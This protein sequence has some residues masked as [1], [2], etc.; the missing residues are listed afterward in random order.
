MAKKTTPK[1][2]VSKNNRTASKKPVAKKAVK[3][4]KP[5]PASKKASKPATKK[6]AVKS[7]SKSK[8]S[9]P[10]AKK[11]PA[12]KPVKKVIPA[13]PV[14]HAPAK[15]SKPAK[16]AAKPAPKISAKIISST[17]K[18]KSPVKESSK[19]SEKVSSRTAPANM[20]P[21]PVAKDKKKSG[22]A[23]TAVAIGPVKVQVPVI[24][25]K[26]KVIVDY[27]NVPDEVLKSLSEKY[28]HGYNKAII[29][30]TNAKKEV[31]SAVPIDVSDTSYL[32]KVS[33]QLQKM[34]D[35]YDEEEM[36][37]DTV[38]AIAEKEIPAGTTSDFEEFDRSDDDETPKRS[39]T[40][41]HVRSADDLE[42]GFSDDDEEEDDDDDD[43]EDEE[44]EVS[45]EDDDDED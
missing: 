35:D 14:K 18:H 11:K 25:G 37:D 1:K 21:A 39:K 17:D 6:T 34:V 29:K 10:A 2:P 16:V 36:F 38:P 43:D 23:A 44:E 9:K 27:K 42:Y 45:D 5:A 33:T 12:P 4:K 31:V 19:T 15:N 32:V 7:V 22:K 24:G 20:A 30:F 13:K 8:A 3:S 26:R 28:P 40:K 41:G